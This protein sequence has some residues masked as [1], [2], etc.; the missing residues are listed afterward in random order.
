MQV[1]VERKVRKQK[2]ARQIH[3]L[4]IPELE[5]AQSIKSDPGFLRS[6]PHL[7]S[8]LALFQERDDF[9]VD[10]ENMVVKPVNEEQFLCAIESNLAKLNEDP[11]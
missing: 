4:K 6:N 9:E 10:E 11:N 1:E 7:I 2:Q 8:L 3:A 5:V